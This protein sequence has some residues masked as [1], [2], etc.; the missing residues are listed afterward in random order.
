MVTIANNYLTLLTVVIPACMPESQNLFQR[1]TT[2]IPG[3]EA[4]P[5]SI[6]RREQDQRGGA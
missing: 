2:V 6:Q 3:S 1:A 4:R 5:G